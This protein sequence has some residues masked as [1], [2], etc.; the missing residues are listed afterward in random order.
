MLRQKAI[1]SKINTV[2]VYNK[3]EKAMVAECV[4][5]VLTSKGNEWCHPDK[6]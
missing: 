2:E 6:I 5:E 3:E 1:R 4:L